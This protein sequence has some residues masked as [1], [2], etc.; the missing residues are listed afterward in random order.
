MTDITSTGNRLVVETAK[1]HQK[2]YRNQSGL[3]LLEGEKAISE[4][5]SAGIEVQNLFVMDG[6]KEKYCNNLSI[7]KIKTV[8]LA[9]MKKLSTTDTPPEAAAVCVQRQ[10]TLSDIDKFTKIAALENIRDAGNLGTI[11]RSAAA[12]RIEG[13]VLCGDCIDLY[14]PK[15]VR[16]AAGNLFKLPIVSVGAVKDLKKLSGKRTYIA[17]VVN[18]ND[19]VSPDNLDFAKS[20]VLMTG[21]EADGLTKEAVDMADVKTTIKISDRVE[22]LNLSIAASILFYIAGMQN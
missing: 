15:V 20:F 22:S 18:H 8:N 1:L 9:V 4:A 13:L 10:Y 21:S 12:F 16:S 2:K 17:T 14:N 5:V 3:F 6:Q 7:E 19:A 11:I